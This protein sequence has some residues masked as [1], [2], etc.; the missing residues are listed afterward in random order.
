MFS[1]K[2]CRVALS[3]V[4]LT[5]VA[6]ISTHAQD[7]D[8]FFGVGTARASSTNQQVDT[9]GNGTLYPTP[10]MKG[11]FGTFG[12]NYMVRPH[13]GMGA[14]YSLKFTQSP[15]AGLKYRPYFYDF[16]AVYIPTRK[17]NRIVPELQAGLGGAKLNFYYNSQFCSVFAGCK[18]SNTFLESSNHFQLHMGGGIRQ[19]LEVVSVVRNTRMG[20]C[21][22]L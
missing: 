4:I 16:N 5:F 3:L 18:T 8:V 14:E 20:W 6:V 11:T 1:S 19:D 21:I 7:A 13:L 2:M 9:F 17:S 15:Y 22:F 12:A 10:E